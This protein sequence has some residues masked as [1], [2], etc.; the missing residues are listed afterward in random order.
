MEVFSGHPDVLLYFRMILAYFGPDRYPGSPGRPCRPG[1]CPGC[2]NP[3]RAHAP[4]GTADPPAINRPGHCGPWGRP[5]P[6]PVGTGCLAGRGCGRGRKPA[7]ARCLS[8]SRALASALC[9][10]SA[11]IALMAGFWSRIL[12]SKAVISAS[13]VRVPASSCFRSSWAGSFFVG[14][15]ACRQRV[16]AALIASVL[17]SPGP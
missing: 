2:D 13:L 10:S 9:S 4:P 3:R 17:R 1:T 14:L 16:R 5:R 12:S 11:T 6:D 7:S 8:A 15:K